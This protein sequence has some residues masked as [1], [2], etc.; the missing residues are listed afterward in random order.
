MAEPEERVGKRI[1]KAGKFELWVA[2][3]ERGGWSADLWSNRGTNRINGIVTK[4][5]RTRPEAY[6]AALGMK[7]KW[8]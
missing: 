1:A 8:F 2:P 5:F 6:R 3:A 4:W 7:R